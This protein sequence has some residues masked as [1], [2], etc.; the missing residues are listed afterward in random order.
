MAYFLRLN[1]AVVVPVL[2]GEAQR[3]ED[4][5]VGGRLVRGIDGT[6]QS[7]Q[8]VGKQH[9]E[10]GTPKLTQAEFNA[11]E[12]A[13]TQGVKVPVDGVIFEGATKDCYVRRTSSMPRWAGADVVKHEMTLDIEEA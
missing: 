6:P 11:I 7:T 9:W 2:D 3:L 12:A 10:V 13:Y 4:I 1:N 8:A 5:V